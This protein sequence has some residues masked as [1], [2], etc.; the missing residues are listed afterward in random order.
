MDEIMDK[1]LELGQDTV[2]ITQTSPLGVD[3][4][5]MSIMPTLV[6][7][8]AVYKNYVGSAAEK[9]VRSYILVD[10]HKRAKDLTGDMKMILGDEWRI[11]Y[12]HYV[13][14]K[15]NLADKATVLFIGVYVGLI[16]L[17]ASGSTLS[18][19]QLTGALRDKKDIFYAQKYGHQ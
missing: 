18:I 1:A 19:K 14:Y 7:D 12:S 4:E 3:N 16:F 8:D 17:I 15:R 10:N 9:I 6:V 13:V 11:H 5:F 2:Y